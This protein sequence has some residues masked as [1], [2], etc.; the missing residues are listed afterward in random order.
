MSLETQ[1]INAAKAGEDAKVSD[2]LKA[3]AKVD[4]TDHDGNTALIWA[5][6]KELTAVRVLLDAGVN[7]NH[8]NVDGVT[9]LIWTASFGHIAV[10]DV[11][12]R[13]LIESTIKIT[14]RTA[15]MQELDRLTGLITNNKTPTPRTN[16]YLGLGLSESGQQELLEYISRIRA[17]RE[18]DPAVQEAP[19]SQS[20]LDKLLFDPSCDHKDDLVRSLSPELDFGPDGLEA[21]YRSR[22]LILS[23][24]VNPTQECIQ[25]TEENSILRKTFRELLRLRDFV[26]ADSLFCNIASGSTVSI[27]S[28]ILYGHIIMHILGLTNST[29]IEQKMIEGVKA[30]FRMPTATEQRVKARRQQGQLQAPPEAVASCYIAA[31]IGAVRGSALKAQDAPTPPLSAGASARRASARR[32]L[33]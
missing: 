4:Y 1:L 6:G 23:F 25:A 19:S 14:D 33:P 22:Q 5:A 9:A 10:V 17:V 28:D 12:L 11:L 29:A 30:L 32:R 15:A 18:S 7:F 3:G 21:D 20:K 8:A 13:G 26:L 2:L 16:S 24:I 27:R 31:L